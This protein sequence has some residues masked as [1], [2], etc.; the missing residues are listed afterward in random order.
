MSEP[1]YE[2]DIPYLQLKFRGKVRDI[3]DLGDELLLV[4]TDRLSAFDVV[5]PD[6]IPMKGEILTETS[7]FWFEKMKGIIVNH[8]SPRP[9]SEIFQ[10]KTDLAQY[11]K[12]SMLVKKT[13]PLAVESIVRGYL[14]GSGWLDYKKTGRVCGIKLPEGMKEASQLSEPIFTPS[15][16]APVGTH[17][18]NISFDDAARTVG[19][20]VLEK[21]RD[22]SLRIYKEAAAFAEQRGIIIADTKFEFGLRDGQLTLIDEVLTPDSSRFWPEDQYRVGISPPSFDKQFVR[23]YLNSIGWNKKPP[24]PKLPPEIIRKTSEKYLEALRRLTQ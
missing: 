12:R 4:A 13:E 18:E 11:G 9:M 21:V 16:K 17:D 6:P 22:T 20:T 5:F 7:L 8:L 23:D 10:S 2:S 3:Y 24:A 19:R 1:L 14:A 15:T